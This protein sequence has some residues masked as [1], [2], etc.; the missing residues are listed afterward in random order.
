VILIGGAVVTFLLRGAA[1]ESKLLL[2][3]LVRQRE[4]GSSLRR[5]ETSLRVVSL[6]QRVRR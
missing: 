1:E 2:E 3:E 6:P 5:L 4:V